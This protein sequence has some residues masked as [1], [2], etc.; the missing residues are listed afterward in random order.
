MNGYLT[1]INNTSL[2]KRSG[3]EPAQPQEM[4][5]KVWNVMM[6]AVGAEGLWQKHALF[7]ITKERSWFFLLV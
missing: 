3:C 1:Q 7:D 4:T 5:V 6:G 2:K